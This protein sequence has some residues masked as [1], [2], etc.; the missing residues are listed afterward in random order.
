MGNGR[1]AWSSRCVASALARAMTW[2]GGARRPASHVRYD[3]GDTPSMA[4]NAACDWPNAIRH[5]RSVRGSYPRHTQK[6]AIHF[7]DHVIKKFPFRIHTVRTD[8]GHEFQAQFHWHLADQGIQHV[9]IKAVG[10]I[11]VPSGTGKMEIP[12][13][14]PMSLHR[15][16]RR[17]S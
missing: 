3:S 1:G 15:M 14:V 4:A 13:W 10:C 11:T 8:R 9:Y 5:S 6:N 17:S 7:L 12:D 2:G 16:Q